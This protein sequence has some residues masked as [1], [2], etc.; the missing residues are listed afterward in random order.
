MEKREKSEKRQTWLL[1]R[2]F[3]WRL[4]VSRVPMRSHKNRRRCRDAMK[5][6]NLD[7]KGWR[8]EWC[9]RES[10]LMMDFAMHSALDATHPS[11]ERFAPE[12]TLLLCMRCHREY[13]NR[14][15]AED[16][17]VS[18]MAPDTVEDAKA[19]AI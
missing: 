9:G 12:N 6:D 16:S 14:K 5:R 4:Y 7:A 10:G 19:E 2:L 18:G 15:R 17:A 8:C 13:Q 3:G 11:W 1:G